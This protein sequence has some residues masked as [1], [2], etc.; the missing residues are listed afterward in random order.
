MRRLPAKSPS[1]AGIAL[2]I[3]AAA[4]VLIRPVRRSLAHGRTD[5]GI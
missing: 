1:P 4:L 2:L 3:L 5:R